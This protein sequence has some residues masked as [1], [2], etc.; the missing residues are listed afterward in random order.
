MTR[1]N[2]VHTESD[3]KQLIMMNPPVTYE[4]QGN[5][6]TISYNRPDNLNTINGACAKLL[7][8]REEILEDET[9]WVAIL[10]GLAT[11]FQPELT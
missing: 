5:V 7:T 2:L 4:Q 9:A 11:S 3:L 10:T 8:L 1:L 6:V